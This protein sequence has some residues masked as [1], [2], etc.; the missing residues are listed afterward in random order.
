MLLI[1]TEKREDCKV[2]VGL[3]REMSTIVPKIEQSFQRIT[4]RDGEGFLLLAAITSCDCFH[5]FAVFL[6]NNPAI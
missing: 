5:L 2:Y 4:D 3:R 6:I 1:P